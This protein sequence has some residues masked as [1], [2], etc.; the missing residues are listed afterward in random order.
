MENTVIKLEN[1]EKSYIL[2]KNEVPILKGIDLDIKKG[3]FLAIIGPSGSGK[4]TTMNMIGSLD[5]PTRGIIYLDNKD[6]SKL[7][8][9]ELAQL[10]GKKIGFIFQ[11]FNLIPSLTALQNVT[12]PLTFQGIPKS[13]A[14]KRA[15]QELEKVKLDH[16]LTHKPTELSGGERQRVAIAR[17][18]V[19]N[20]EVIL[21]DEPTGNL[22]SKTGEE[23]M[24]L[25]KTLN[26]QHNKTVVI[27]THDSNIARRAKRVIKI[28]DGRIVK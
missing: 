8:E 24:E 25:L 5:T 2:A 10:R 23:I 26:E 16:R 1:V 18:L 9:S 19:T 13:E 22:D 12:L 4:S 3:E 21:A 17:A 27:I 14:T 7:D 11:N 6:I 28:Q 15:K 20:S